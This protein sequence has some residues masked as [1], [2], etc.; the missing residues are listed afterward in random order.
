MTEKNFVIMSNNLSV[1]TWII[2]CSKKNGDYGDNDIIIIDG[3][4][5]ANHHHHHL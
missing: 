4:G 3:G 5:G 2:S 1:C